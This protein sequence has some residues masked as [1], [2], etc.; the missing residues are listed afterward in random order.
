MRANNLLSTVSAKVTP[1]LETSRL[2]ASH[3]LTMLVRKTCWAGILAT[4][5][6][7]CLYQLY[8]IHQVYQTNA[9]NKNDP[10]GNCSPEMVYSACQSLREEIKQKLSAS[11]ENVSNTSSNCNDS[12]G[13]LDECAELLERI[14]PIPKKSYKGKEDDDNNERV[15]LRYRLAFWYGCIGEWELFGTH[16]SK[17]KDIDELRDLLKTA[18]AINARHREVRKLEAFMACVATVALG[19]YYFPK[20]GSLF[21]L[22]V[23]GCWVAARF[24]ADTH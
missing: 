17:V 15:S 8:R 11:T 22:G 13:I 20:V 3:P 5:I 1:F 16:G 21:S 4:G 18:S 23:G 19:V 7:T 6:G 10:W 24:R 9:M 2:L 12:K 14:D